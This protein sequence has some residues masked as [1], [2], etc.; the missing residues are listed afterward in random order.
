MIFVRRLEGHS[1]TASIKWSGAEHLVFFT[2]NIEYL[3]GVAPKQI[4]SGF[5][6]LYC[7]PYTSIFCCPI[8]LNL[9]INWPPP[10]IQSYNSSVLLY[11]VLFHDNEI[12]RRSRMNAGWIPD[13]LL[14]KEFSRFSRKD[15]FRVESICFWDDAASS[16]DAGTGLRKLMTSP[17]KLWYHHP[18]YILYLD[19]I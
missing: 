15:V 11:I 17:S 12:P 9:L 4:V 2:Y 8:W 13:D 7:D 1:M 6:F 18:G 5:P 16:S 14:T 3:P 19:Q 10:E